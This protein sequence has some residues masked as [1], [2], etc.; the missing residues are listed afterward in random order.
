MIRSKISR[1]YLSPIRFPLHS[2]HVH[3]T[4]VD[5]P[6]QIMVAVSGCVY[7][8]F[9]C[10][11]DT[12]SATHNRLVHMSPCRK[13]PATYRQ[14]PH[15]AVPTMNVCQYIRCSISLSYI[16]PAYL[17][18]P[19]S[20]HDDKCLCGMKF[21]FIM[22]LVTIGCSLIKADPRVLWSH[23]TVNNLCAIY[24]SIGGERV[25]DHQLCRTPSNNRVYYSPIHT[26]S[27]LSEQ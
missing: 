21:S 17:S 14:K 27:L 25:D 5:W 10:V 4:V 16:K 15:Q 1:L 24:Y 19:C 11:L 13:V 18:H 26:M 3:L 9:R 20:V 8:V 6:H 22:V 12:S 23:E 2:D 7:A